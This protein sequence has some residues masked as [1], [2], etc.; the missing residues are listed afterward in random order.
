MDEHIKIKG[1]I[2]ATGNHRVWLKNKETTTRTAKTV[3]VT[4]K[5][6]KRDF[7]ILNQNLPV[8]LGIDHLDEELIAQYPLLNELDLLNVGVIN[9]I[10]LSDEGI[11]I[12]DAELSNPELKR[13]YMEGKLSDFSIVADI[14][15]KECL[16]DGVDFVED[17]SHIK[18]VDFVGQGACSSCKIEDNPTF[19]NASLSLNNNNEGEIMVD[20]E[21]K[22]E[23]KKDEKQVE[24]PESIEELIEVVDGLTKRVE[25]LEEIVGVPEKEEKKEEEAEASKPPVADDSISKLTLE[26]EKLK[27]DKLQLEANNAVE[28]YMKEGKIL[29]KDIA[30]H[31]AIAMKTPEE[32][33]ELMA[34]API[35]VKL[36]RLSASDSGD[37]ESD[38]EDIFKEYNEYKSQT[39]K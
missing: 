12:M 4:N 14:H 6:L 17:Y 39:K 34:T 8:P 29:P 28:G 20:V 1:I 10:K 38:D 31:Q 7:D 26:V 25:A 9:K 30:K 37:N 36:D 32:Y 11:R 22:K 18:R 35:V 15:T 16:E 21:N 19:L 5:S 24:T 23:N 27:K 13:L 33:K 3:K 2:W